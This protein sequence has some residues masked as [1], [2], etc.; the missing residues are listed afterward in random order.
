MN[1]YQISMRNR[2]FHELLRHNVH[3]LLRYGVDIEVYERAHRRTNGDI[4]ELVKWRVW[5]RIRARMKLR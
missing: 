3:E 1:Q 5:D 4:S 2:T